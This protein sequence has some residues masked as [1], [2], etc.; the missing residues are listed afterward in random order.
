MTRASLP[1]PLMA[2]QS[3]LEAAKEPQLRERLS[4]AIRRVRRLYGLPLG[5]KEETG[6]LR[7]PRLGLR[8]SQLRRVPPEAAS[9][10]RREWRDRIAR[11]GE[12]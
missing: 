6:D 2:L 3:N 7:R 10:Y 8:V 1:R 4:E 11:E 5:E 12:Q 9:A